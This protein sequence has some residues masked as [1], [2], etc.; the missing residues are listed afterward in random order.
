[1]ITELGDLVSIRCVFVS[2][3][4]S[5]I[6]DGYPESVRHGS[7][8]SSFA[9]HEWLPAWA[10]LAWEKRPTEWRDAVGIAGTGPPIHQRQTTPVG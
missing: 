5:K 2:F 1:M 3:A 10:V 7:N 6:N 8:F 9:H 4:W